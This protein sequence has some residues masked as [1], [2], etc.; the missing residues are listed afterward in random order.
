MSINTKLKLSGY[1]ILGACLLTISACG[2]GRA[3]I[4]EAQEKET[5]EL[6]STGG[7]SSS[8]EGL[9]LGYACCNLRYSGDWVSDQSSGELPFIPV[10]TQI[11]V[12][13]LEGSVAHIVVDEKRYRL[14]HDYGRHEEK[15]AEWVDKLVVLNNP[16]TKLGRYPAAIRAAIET[17]KI[18]RGMNREQVIMALGYPATNETSKL[19]APVWKYYWNR[20]GFSVHWS[21]GQVSKIEGNPEIVRQVQPA[22]ASTATQPVGKSKTAGKGGATA[23]TKSK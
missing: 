6:A 11:L 8:A 10:G 21:G 19:D 5:S 13:R 12:R 17:G 22:T 3:A 18:T 2:S 20:Y 16:A 9:R 23:E 15:T 4:K 7:R 14:G 1:F